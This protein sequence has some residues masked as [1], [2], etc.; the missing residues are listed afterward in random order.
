MDDPDAMGAVGKSL[1]ALGCMGRSWLLT[2]NIG[3]TQGGGSSKPW[4]DRL[5]HSRIWWTCTT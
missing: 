4:H 1:G 5:W 3:A 2:L